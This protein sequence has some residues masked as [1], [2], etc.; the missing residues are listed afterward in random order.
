MRTLQTSQV[1]L[2]G[3]LIAKSVTLVLEVLIETLEVESLMMVVVAAVAVI[4]MMVLVLVLELKLKLVL[5]LLLWV[6]VLML[7]FPVKVIVVF[8][9]LS[10]HLVQLVLLALRR[11]QQEVG[12]ERVQV[13]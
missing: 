12:I 7:E 3:C 8:A 5:L 4:V 11:V 10:H 1:L 13:R 2:L 6:L 9:Q